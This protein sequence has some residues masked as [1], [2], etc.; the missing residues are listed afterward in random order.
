MISDIPELDRVTLA[1]VRNC[2]AVFMNLTY[3]VGG[4]M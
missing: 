1:L 3:R 4:I 2:N